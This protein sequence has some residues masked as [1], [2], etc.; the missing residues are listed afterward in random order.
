MTMEQAIRKYLN[1]KCSNA[2]ET[3]RRPARIPL[4]P[5]GGRRAAANLENAP[6]GDI[7]K[8]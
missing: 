8:E 3:H 2:E 7:L 1:E 4:T 5:R 6:P